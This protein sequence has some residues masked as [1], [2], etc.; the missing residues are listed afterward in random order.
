MERGPRKLT[1]RKSKVGFVF[2]H[3]AASSPSVCGACGVR[4]GRSGTPRAEIKARAGR[5]ARPFS[6]CQ[7]G[8]GGPRMSG[9]QRQRN[10]L[11]GHWR[12]NPR[13]AADETGRRPGC[14]V[15]QGPATR[16]ARRTTRCTWTTVS[17]PMTRRGSRGRR[18][19]LVINEGRVEQIGS[20]TTSTTAAQ[21]F[22]HEVPGPVTT[23][24]RQ[25]V[26]PQGTWPLCPGSGDGR[27]ALARRRD[28]S[29]A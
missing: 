16:A 27:P 6:T 19:D 17:L 18:R 21:R 7:F 26:R 25:A 8:D 1:P 20:Q 11:A 28:A 13:V 5:A 24:G 3:Y 9:G 12:R 14:K 2:Q 4:T 15:K 22:R 29:R 10:G 23:T